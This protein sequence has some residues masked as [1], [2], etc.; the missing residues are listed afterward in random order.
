MEEARTESWKAKEQELRDR[1]PESRRLH[2]EKA[3]ESCTW[4]LRLSTT[5]PTD[6]N[7]FKK[8]KKKG[9]TKRDELIRE[10]TKVIKFQYK[11]SIIFPHTNNTELEIEEKSMIVSKLFK[12]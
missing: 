7:M 3:A 8:K 1:G 9:T 2:T 4:G 6:C 11:N 5:Q 12:V 10:F